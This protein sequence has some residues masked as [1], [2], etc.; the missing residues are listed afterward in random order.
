MVMWHIK[1]KGMVSRTGYKLKFSPDGQTGNL[2][3]GSKGQ[4]S[5]NLFESEGICD[6]VPTTV[7]S[8]CFCEYICVSTKTCLWGVQTTK[9]QTI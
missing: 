3:V 5:L 2:R 9:A 4:I 1:L 7:H 8:S 6:S